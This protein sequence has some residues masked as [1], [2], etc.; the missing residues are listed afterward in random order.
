MLRKYIKLL[1]YGAVGFCQ[2]KISYCDP[3][4]LIY[5]NSIQT[6]KSNKIDLHKEFVDN[7]SNDLDTVQRYIIKNRL[8][9]DLIK[10]K[11][12]SRKKLT[13]RE[14]AKTSSYDECIDFLSKWFCSESDL[15]EQEFRYYFSTYFK[16][17]TSEQIDKSIGQ[18]YD[19]IDLERCAF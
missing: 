7:K 12:E 11:F 17:F 15:D 18:F 9:G 2:Y 1:S 3:N 14:F 5:Y 19:F 8:N 6:N 13:F 16:D 4:I 10:E